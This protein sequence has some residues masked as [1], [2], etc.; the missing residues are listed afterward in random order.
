MNGFV[1]DCANSFDA[2]QPAASIR[3]WRAVRCDTAIVFNPDNVVVCVAESGG[4]VRRRDIMH[5]GFLGRVA[6]DGYGP[7]YEKILERWT[8]KRMNGWPSE[9]I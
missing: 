1:S 7:W 3:L 8:L 9:R 4:V 5:I 6:G 2:G